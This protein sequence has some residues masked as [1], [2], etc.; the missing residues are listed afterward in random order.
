[1]KKNSNIS[2]R[3]HILISIPLRLMGG[4]GGA[5][6]LVSILFVLVS[7]SST[8][9]IPEN[10]QLFVGLKKTQYTNYEANEHAKETQEELDVVLTTLPNGALF[11][12]PY[13]RSPFPIG[14]WVWNSFSQSTTGL[15]KWI[16]K[17][18]GKAPV[19]MS[20]VSPDL[21]AQVGE[22]TLKNNGYFNGKVSYEILQQSNPKKSKVA[23]TVDMGHLWTLDTISYENFPV[24]ADNIIHDN[25]DNAYIKKGDPF[26]VSALDQERQRITN[27]FRDNGYYYYE[28]N[29]ASYLAD[30]LRVPGK[31]SL[32]L[33]MADSLDERA[34]HKWY[35]GN[36]DVNLRRSFMEQLD[37]VRGR[38]WFKLHYNGKR[39]PVRL[40]VIMN[41]LR[42][43]HGEPYGRDLHEESLVKLNGTGLFSYANFSFTPRD[44]SATCDTL[45]MKLDCVL[46]KRYD[47]YIETYA[48]GKTNGRVGPE[49][50]VGLTKRNAFRG[51]EKL[52]FN[53]HGSY[54]WQTGHDSE[55]STSGVNSYEY[56]FDAALEFPRILNPFEFLFKP[57]SKLTPEQR[58]KRMEKMRKRRSRFYDVPTTTLKASLNVLNRAGYFKRHVVSGEI[59]Y[60]WQTSAQS[61]FQW[62][63][64]ILSYEYMK[65]KTA[66]FEKLLEENPY[67][68]KSME[69][70]FVP[71]MQFSY[72][73]RSPL[74]Y[75][76]PISWWTTISE[77]SNILSLGYAIFGEKWSEKGKTMFKNP[78]AQFFKVETNFTKMWHLSEKSSV[79]GHA[80]V[81]VLWCYGNSDFAPY[82]ELFYVGGAN[83]I[84][85]F[86][87]R[88][89]GPGKYFPETRR[90]SYVEQT[91]DL[92][93]QFN[94]E[95]RPHLFGNVYGAL[96]LDAGNVWSLH[97]DDTRPGAKFYFKN[98]IKEMALGTGIGLRYDLGFFTIRLDWG[99][100]LHVPYE[101]GKSGFYNIA[102]FKDGQAF[103]LAIGMPF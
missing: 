55:G 64:F 33:Q 43:K 76:N 97:E 99:I 36:I 102:K 50:I 26:N 13:Y 4:V 63:P 62:S 68:Q 30:T 60:R 94:L 2:S 75:R 87:V 6:L 46:D 85:A 96:F 19:L 83:S 16:N 25:L 29:D 101:T 39:S 88:S 90:M 81:G 84:R 17:A 48:R 79:V 100:G 52:D 82:S 57:F 28:K 9:A 65:N 42:L 98:I 24:E 86:N 23:Y 49:L 69:D 40:N 72:D 5:L 54:E 31:V 38:R 93:V 11:G 67:L 12:S 3:H 8:K 77:A 27:L 74:T 41:G 80:N 78:Y 22:S 91:G 20:V 32:R 51:G 89:I 56:G 53:L 21:H 92:K 1:M 58:R 95:Y 15:G 7:C 10:D 47:F 59:T 44:S 70:Q 18:F 71:K 73:Y 14:L 34:L 61:L 37:S 103:H 35:I 66:D 45:D